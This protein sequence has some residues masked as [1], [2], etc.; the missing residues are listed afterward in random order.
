MRIGGTHGEFGSWLPSDL[1]T[2]ARACLLASMGRKPVGQTAITERVPAA[3]DI[4]LIHWSGTDFAG[5][6]GTNVLKCLLK[7]LRSLIRSIVLKIE[8]AIR[9]GL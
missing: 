1:C 6:Q 7:P 5:N 2:T 3:C 9:R 8:R 4:R